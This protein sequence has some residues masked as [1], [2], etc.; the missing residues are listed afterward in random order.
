[1]STKEQAPTFTLTIDWARMGDA[2][3]E[4]HDAF[5]AHRAAHLD[6]TIHADGSAEY[7]PNREALETVKLCYRLAFMAKRASGG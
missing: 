4:A 5:E 1:V 2:F 6:V 3:E 7:T